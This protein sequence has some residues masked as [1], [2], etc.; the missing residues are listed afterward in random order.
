MAEPHSVRGNF[1]RLV[2]FVKRTIVTD[3]PEDLALCEF[4]CRRGQCQQDE[5]DTCDRRIRKAAG[6]LFPDQ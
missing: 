3:V 4:D 1:R 6:E 2:R 5:W